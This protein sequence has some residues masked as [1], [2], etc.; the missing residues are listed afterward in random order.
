[1]PERVKTWAGD[2]EGASA[3]PPDG[4]ASLRR[5]SRRV[6]LIG[7]VAIGIL[8]GTALTRALE[9]VVVT[10]E[11]VLPVEA[12]A[13]D[14]SREAVFLE[15]MLQAVVEASRP[16]VSG[17]VTADPERAQ[18]LVD[19]LRPRVQGF[20]VSFRTLGEPVR[21]TSLEDPGLEEVA[22]G[23]TA[24]VDVAQLRAFLHAQGL[25]VER[26]SL[27][28]ILLHVERA[29]GAELPAGAETGPLPGLERVLADRLQQE[30]AVLIDPTLRPTPIGGEAETPLRLARRLGADVA[31]VIQVGWS[32]GAA[33]D[34]GLS[35]GMA[36]VVAR[37]VRASDGAEVA[38][39]RFEAPGYHSEARRALSNALEGLR[40]QVAANAVQQLERNWAAISSQQGPVEIWLREARGLLQVDAI[41]TAIRESLGAS[42]VDLLELSSEGVRLR[43]ESPLAAGALI[44]RLSAMAF[45][46]FRLE[47]VDPS[48][49]RAEMRIEPSPRSME[50]EDSG[51]PRF[52]TGSQY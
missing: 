40:E 31:L 10:A 29:P 42:R 17:E 2:R 18:A 3:S 47:P 38:I 11:G 41:R 27:P 15:A 6:V 21:R 28:S 26:P 37:A 36:S 22:L 19:A 34:V 20:L 5:R 14:P 25:L 35:G 45:D 12:N 4:A 13:A 30:G 23:I 1:M 46:G 48:L 44:E 16:Y 43:V 9:P 8:P 7:L 33:T 51:A 52:D 24:T 32:V 50:N 49:G 39:A